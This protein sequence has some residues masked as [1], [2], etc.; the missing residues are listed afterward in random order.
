MGPKHMIW[1]RTT[2]AHCVEVFW[3]PVDPSRPSQGHRGGQKGPKK[4]LSLPFGRFGPR[5]G[6]RGARHQNVKVS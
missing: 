1:M 3:V 4:P 5:K 6:L 2:Q